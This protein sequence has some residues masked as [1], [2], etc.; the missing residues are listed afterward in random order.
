MGV[1]QKLRNTDT[2]LSYLIHHV[3]LP[4]KLPC[5][6]DYKPEHEQQLLSVALKSLEGF[7]LLAAAEHRDIC[8]NAI[9]ALGTTRT[10]HTCAGNQYVI[11][12]SALLLAMQHLDKNG[13]CELTHERDTNRD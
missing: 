9:D 8:D 3:F 10:I 5:A 2:E 4:P 7:R 6:D 1:L 12:R 11:D 13:T